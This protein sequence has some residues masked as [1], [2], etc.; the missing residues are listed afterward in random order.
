MTV[1]TVAMEN[2]AVQ[3]ML[4]EACPVIGGGEY[5]PGLLLL[6][7]ARLHLEHTHSLLSRR[8]AIAGRK[9][10]FASR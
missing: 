2:F 8:L 7:A 6:Q 10:N 1:L 9:T 5:A 3:I 4:P